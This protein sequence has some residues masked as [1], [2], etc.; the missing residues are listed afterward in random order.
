M[1]TRKVKTLKQTWVRWLDLLWGLCV[2]SKNNRCAYC[3]KSVN[4]SKLDA[5][6][7]F[8][9]GLSI[10]FDPKTGI[11]LCYYCHHWRLMKDPEGMRQCFVKYVGGEKKYLKLYE[12]SKIVITD[13]DM[14][15]FF[16]KYEKILLNEL[17]ILKVSLP[18]KP[19][20]LSP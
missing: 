13:V 7:I 20:R 10:R 19:K 5:H 11:L 3:G 8:H 12:K 4:E 18:Q 16:K 1:K 2:H 14:V 15:S 17:K 9:R 6:H